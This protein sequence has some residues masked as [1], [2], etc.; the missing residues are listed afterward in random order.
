MQD[1]NRSL[2][3]FLIADSI[4]SLIGYINIYVEVVQCAGK[5]HVRFWVFNAKDETIFIHLSRLNTQC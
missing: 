5:P 2:T 4:V 3:L 1:I